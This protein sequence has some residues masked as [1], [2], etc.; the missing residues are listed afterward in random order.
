[1]EVLKWI[2]LIL[3][4]IAAAGLIYYFLI[5]GRFK[6]FLALEA[7]IKRDPSD[8][9][10]REYMHCYQHTFIPDQPKIKASRAHFYQSIK[11]SNQ[12]SYEVK[13][14]L[15]HFFEE[16][17]VTVLTTMAQTEEEQNDDVK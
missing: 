10:V 1:M 6:K 16:Q 7:K 15:R 2:L 8:E 5:I 17:G 4:I 13:K 11:A 3:L 9:G 12:V 14:E